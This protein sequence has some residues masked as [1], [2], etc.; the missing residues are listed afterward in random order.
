MNTHT[1][2]GYVIRPL[3]FKSPTLSASLKLE[4]IPHSYGRQPGGGREV[5][6]WLLFPPGAGQGAGGG[7]TVFQ[8]LKDYLKSQR[9]RWL[10]CAN[11]QNFM[12][13]AGKKIAELTA[14]ASPQKGCVRVFPRARG[15]GQPERRRG[16]RHW[17]Y[18]TRVCLLMYA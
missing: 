9:D 12:P 11:S 3:H 13:T 18:F 4:S 5:E 10:L 15:R 2:G 8:S 1:Q 14:E 7:A 17:I 6:T 16:I